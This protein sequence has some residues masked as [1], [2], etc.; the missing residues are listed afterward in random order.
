MYF[1]EFL[2]LIGISLEETK[3]NLIS[4]A[5]ASGHVN[6]KGEIKQ[7]FFY[8]LMPPSSKYQLKKDMKREIDQIQNGVN[9]PEIKKMKKTSEAFRESE[10]PVRCPNF[11]AQRLQ[12]EESKQ[13]LNDPKIQTIIHITFTK[14]DEVKQIVEIKFKDLSKRVSQV[15]NQITGIAHKVRSLQQ[16]QRSTTSRGRGNIRR[17]RARGGRQRNTISRADNI[18]EVEE[19]LGE[20][21]EEEFWRLN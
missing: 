18:Q 13:M 6:E 21:E 7:L 20:E 14:M 16:S 12:E 11:S 17:A 3:T 1:C 15:E 2:I 8:S 9:E 10:S 4:K 19:E 5:K